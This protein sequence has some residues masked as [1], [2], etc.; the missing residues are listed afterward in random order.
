MRAAGRCHGIWHQARHSI[1]RDLKPAN[2]L[3]TE[4][5]APKI[6][7][8]G[9]VKRLEEDAGQTLSGSILGTA[10]Y[11]APEQADGRI[12]EIGPRSDLYALGGILYE[13]M[14]G[15]PPFRAA[16]VLDT[17]LQ[18]RTQDPIAP[19]QFQP[20]LPRDLETICL[21]MPAKGPRQALCHGGRFRRGPSFVPGRRAHSAAARQL[22]WKGFGGGAVRNPG[23]RRPGRDRGDAGRGLGGHLD[24]ALPPGPGQRAD[25]SGQRLQCQS[26]RL[27]GRAQRPGG[28][29]EGPGGPYQ[30]RDGA[31]ERRPG[32]SAN[33]A[34]ARNQERSPAQGIAQDSIAQ[35]IQLGEQ[36]MRRLRAKHDPRRG[37][38]PN[39]LRLGGDLLAML[40]KEMV[41]LAERI[42][43]QGV[44]PFAFATLHQ[45][46]GDLLRKLGQFDDA[47]REF[48]QA[49]DRIAR[50][51]H[52][53]PNNDVTRANLG[54]MLVRLGELS[55][56]D[57]GGDVVALARDEFGR[58]WKLQEEIALHPRSGNYSK[59]D[60]HRLLSGI[61]VKQGSAELSLGHPGLARE[62]CRKARELRQAWT[63]AEPGNVSG[64]ELRHRKPSPGWASLTAIWPTGRTPRATSTR[65]S[66]SPRCSP[67]SIRSTRASRGTWLR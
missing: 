67:A 47:R 9:L 43:S 7:D 63:K 33:E 14:T 35:M 54:V 28:L 56:V 5:G 46:M 2:V 39:G 59:A 38:R 17:L 44:S 61:A 36:M 60:N 48:Q 31:A 18:V 62:R 55:C 65:L 32:S 37:P 15:R 22:G 49:H 23:N 51:A 12:K 52:D 27:T 13:L 57:Q 24:L 50:V 40:R 3:L 16:S 6:S 1:H 41:P 21:E 25:R 4:S 19:S 66:G 64:A 8:F 10:S 42:E 58:A 26:K 53:Q 45:R 20:K 34:R 11:M 30:R 29:V